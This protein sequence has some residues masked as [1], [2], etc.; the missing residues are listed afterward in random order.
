MQHVEGESSVIYQ[1]ISILESR[2]PSDCEYEYDC[3]RESLRIEEL[4]TDKIVCLQRLCELLAD[5]YISVSRLDLW[6]NLISKHIHL[7]AIF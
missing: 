6:S 5:N 3:D 7:L 4:G 2:F 1:T